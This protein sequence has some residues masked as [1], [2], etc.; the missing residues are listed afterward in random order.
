MKKK[1]IA[2][3]LIVAIIATC[4]VALAACNKDKDEFIFGLIT[5]HDSSSTYDKNFIDAAQAACDELGVKLIVKSGIDETDACYNTAMDLVDQGCDVIFAD[6]FGHE[7][8]MLK[9]AK[10]ATNVQFYHATGFRAG[11]A[12]QAN[13]HDAFASIYQGRYLAGVAAGMKLAAMKAANPSTES[14]VGYVG[15]Y[16]YAE[17]VSGLTSWYLGVK[18][19][20]SDVT[21]EVQFTGSWFDPTAE[22]TAAE[23]LI[24]RG[25]VVMSQ[26]AD[27]MGAPSA[28]EEASVPDITYN[29]STK[30]SCPNTYVIG[31][32]IDWTPYFKMIINAAKNGTE[33]AADWCGGFDVGAVA[34]T[35]I[36]TA[37]AAGTAEKLA[38]V[39]ASLL[40]GTTQVFDCSTIKYNGKALDQA[41]ADNDVAKDNTAEN[42]HTLGMYAS[43]I[44][45][46]GTSGKYFSESDV[47]VGTSAPYFDL[48]IDG[49]TF[50]NTRF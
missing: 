1:V 21:M 48:Q 46:F 18:S 9:A 2:L 31:S 3:L 32:K 19:I 26:H 10:E 35:E 33:I 6:S 15:A 29:I 25:A 47:S 28:C 37:A 49:I 45:T 38:E 22:K 14:K 5:L 12:N 30:A 8:F 36:G 16:T 40:A 13:F 11:T 7:P 44:K 50:L 34:L 42:P 23:T 24:S 43:Y 27:S 41:I 17:V 4:L 39:K 20:V